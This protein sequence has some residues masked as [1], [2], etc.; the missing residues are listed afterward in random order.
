MVATHL[1]PIFSSPFFKIL[2]DILSPPS[3]TIDY[4]PGFRVNSGFS[5]VVL[6]VHGWLIGS[7]TTGISSF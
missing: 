7:E 1:L 4:E 5:E 6:S 3:Y 2:Y